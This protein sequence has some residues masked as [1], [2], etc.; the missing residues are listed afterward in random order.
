MRRIVTFALFSIA[1][2]ASAQNKDEPKRPNLPAGA[3]TNDAQVYYDH[4]LM[5]LK[6]NPK[7]AADA[8]YWSTRLNPIGGE[9]FYARR[10]ALLMSDKRRLLKYWSDD[11]NTLRSA[12][13]R[14]IDSMYLHALTL[15]PF[16]YEK[17]DQVLFRTIVDEIAN[18]ESIRTGA[19][20]SE[21]QYMID[22]WISRADPGT[23]AWHAYGDGRFQDALRDWATA[24]K[25]ARTK[26]WYRSMRGRLFFQLG[27][28]DSALSELKL[29][30]EEMRKRDNK[31]LVFVYQSKA[32]IEQSI[33]MT[34]VRRQEYNEAK[35]AFGRALQED[36]AYSPAH[37]QL[38]YLALDRKDTTNAISE[39]DLAVQLRP[40]DAGLRYQY[41]WVLVESGKPAEAVTQLAKAIELNASYSL[42]YYA[43]G[44]AH[45]KLGKKDEAAKAYRTFL[46]MAPKHD[47]RRTEVMQ[48]LQ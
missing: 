13:I 17:L 3:D 12:E 31:D 15:N 7:V 46:A 36:L 5:Q 48:K 33:G 28:V 23:K 8:F 32:L 41:G 42:P 35:E 26:Y 25:S 43:L 44:N 34:H 2:A 10:V 29:A 37:V 38:A 18:Q 14:R 11:R 16:L 1:A 9:A 24:V 30:I 27:E 45:D 21:I 22:G 39:F 47:A 4:G 19:P 6:N 20:A 40:D